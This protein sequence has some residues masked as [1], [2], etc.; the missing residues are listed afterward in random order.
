MNACDVL[1]DGGTI[2]IRAKP[3][4]E[5]V[6]IEF[7]DSGPGIPADV[8]R[9]IFDPF[10]T[11]KEVGKGTGL[12]LSLSHGIIER[13]GGRIQIVSRPGEG[14]IFQIELPLVAP[15]LEGEALEAAQPPA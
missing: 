4:D 3:I 9:R 11:T 7:E 5:G 13:H 10:F 14:A 8:Q 12:G 6:R 2:T 15:G 1:E